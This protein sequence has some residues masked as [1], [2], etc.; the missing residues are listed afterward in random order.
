MS[1]K[2]TEVARLEMQLRHWGAG[3]DGLT[4]QVLADPETHLFLFSNAVI[5]LIF[6][7]HWALGVLAYRSFGNL[8]PA[9]AVQLAPIMSTIVLKHAFVPRPESMVVVSTLFL[10]AVLVTALRPGHLVNHGL[11]YAIAFGAAAGF[12]GATKVTSAPI[13]VLPLLV[14]P[15]WRQRFVYVAAAVGFFLLFMTP[16]WEAFPQIAEWIAKVAV[17]AGAHGEGA[18]TVI[19]IEH[20]PKALSKVLKR[21]SLRI[22]IALALITPGLA[23]WR[24]RKGAEINAIDA[25]VLAGVTVSQLVQA[26]VVAKH[27]VAFY[28]IPSYMVSAPSLL[29]SVRLLWSLRPT[30]RFLDR[31]GRHAGMLAV[32]GFIVAQ[33]A[34][35][36]RLDDE[37]SRLNHTALALDNNRFELCSRVYIYAASS[38][39]FALFLADEVTGNRFAARLAELYPGNNYWIEDWYDQMDVTFRNWKGPQD[40]QDVLN[41]SRCLFVRGNRPGGIERF[42]KSYAP[43]VEPSMACSAGVE[44]V[45]TVGVDCEGNIEQ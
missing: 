9:L 22:P 25:R 39:V 18:A 10:M 13:Y 17:G 45:A 1:G 5:V 2:H 36:V 29:L 4:Q 34:A 35:T 12:A 43:G 37:L 21:P 24:W 16:A 11:R 40:F 20:Y 3:L 38:P 33:V 15:G 14:V 41:G 7:G 30:G 31:W 23:W 28:M 8:L 26:A 19:N 6:L 42:I 32:A 44:T 27:P